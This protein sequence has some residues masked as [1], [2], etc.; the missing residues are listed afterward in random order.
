MSVENIIKSSEP[1]LRKAASFDHE[2]ED[3]G[4]RVDAYR[5]TGL[6]RISEEMMRQRIKYVIAAEKLQESAWIDIKRS[7]QDEGLNVDTNKK[8]LADGELD[9]F[10]RSEIMDYYLKSSKTSK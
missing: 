4:G 6:Y 7:F 5:K 2:A 9:I 1:F 3:Y 8:I 10:I